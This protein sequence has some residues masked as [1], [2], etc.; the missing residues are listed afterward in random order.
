MPNVATPTTR[1]S[2][3][4]VTITPV[5]SAA[6]VTGTRIT[7]PVISGLNAAAIPAPTSASATISHA[8]PGPPPRNW[9]ASISSP[10]P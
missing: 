4:T 7:T 5:A 3:L 10:A 6:P 2:W 8:P 1:A 9:A